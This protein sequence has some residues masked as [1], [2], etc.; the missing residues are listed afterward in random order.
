MDRLQFEFT[1]IASNDGKSNVLAIT[2]I[3]TK[4]GKCYVLPDELNPRLLTLV[5]NFSARDQAVF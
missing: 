1:M 5:D 4:E 3:S 2:S